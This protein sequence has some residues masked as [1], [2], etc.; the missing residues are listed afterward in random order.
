MLG[1][2]VSLLQ[3]KKYAFP[4]VGVVLW[5]KRCYWK[6]LFRTFQGI[7]LDNSVKCILL[8][9]IFLA[10]RR[11]DTISKSSVD[12]PGYR[13]P[14]TQCDIGIFNRSFYHLD[15]DS[16]QD[17]YRFTTT[18]YNT[19][20]SDSFQC[21]YVFDGKY[22]EGNYNDYPISIFEMDLSICYVTLTKARIALLHAPRQR[23][24]MQAPLFII[25]NGQ[26]KFVPRND[27]IMNLYIKRMQ[28]LWNQNWDQQSLIR[29]CILNA[30]THEELSLNE[31]REV[32]R[33]S[34]KTVTERY[35]RINYMEKFEIYH[36][37]VSKKL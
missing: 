19:G 20:S 2:I 10:A 32:A 18:L 5:I 15:Q 37:L 16:V 14:P 28:G 3:Q 7:L 1:Q 23:L 26:G 12:K 11:R 34:W 9:S 27:Y 17:W 13:I 29:G 24:T 21:H 6:S 4:A 33:H 35:I 8:F 31:C 36:K 30:S 22:A 25:L